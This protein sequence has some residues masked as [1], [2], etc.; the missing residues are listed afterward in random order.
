[1][2]ANTMQEQKQAP[3]AAAAGSSS[4]GS[5]RKEVLVKQAAGQGMLGY[6]EW[7]CRLFHPIAAVS[8]G[9]EVHWCTAELNVNAFQHPRYKSASCC[10]CHS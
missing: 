1:M 8:A 6:D 9:W 2:P 7:R 4:S 10:L 3:T 5:S